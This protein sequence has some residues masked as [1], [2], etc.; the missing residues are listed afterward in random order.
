MFCTFLHFLQATESSGLYSNSIPEV[1][2]YYTSYSYIDDLAWAA[3]WLALRTGDAEQLREAKFYYDQHWMME[4]GG[5][6]RRCAACF[7]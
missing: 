1:R 3:T 5:E 4:G 2:G 6:G 7:T